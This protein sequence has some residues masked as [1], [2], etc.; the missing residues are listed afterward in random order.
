[1][2]I[3]GGKHMKTKVYEV[4]RDYI[5]D[6]GITM[7]HVSKKTGIPLELLRRSLNGTR[8]LQ[9]DEFISI[10]ACVGIDISDIT[11]SA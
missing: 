11:K 2:N 5:E 4:V 1:M 6:H 8:R 3:K 7:T 9:A 10:C